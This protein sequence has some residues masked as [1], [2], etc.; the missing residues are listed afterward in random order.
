MMFERINTGSD[1]L[2]N[3]EKRKGITRGLFTEFIYKECA[4]NPLFRDLTKFTEKVENRGEAE[5]LILRYFAYLENYNLLIDRKQSPLFNKGTSQAENYAKLIDS[6][7]DF[8]DA[9]IED[10]NKKF[11]IQD[12]ESLTNMFLQMLQ[13][14]KMYFPNGFLKFKGSN[15]TPRVR[16]EALSVGVSLALLENP[17]LTISNVD[18]LESPEFLSEITGSWTGTPKKIKSRI[19]FVKNKLLNTQ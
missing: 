17:D 9:Y 19:E 4:K 10:K 5:E 8:L 2:N 7:S 12:N 1:E 3:M 6:P 13:F 18:W 11:D 14:V 15:K 16:F